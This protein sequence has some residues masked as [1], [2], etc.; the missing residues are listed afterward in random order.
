M[1]QKRNDFEIVG[2]LQK[3]PNHLR[4]IAKYFNLPPS[5]TMRILN[6][7]VEEN[8]LDF[9][10]VGKNKEFFLK[11]SPERKIYE[12]FVEH[13]K[14]LACLQN[15]MIRKITEEIAKITKNNELVI[16]FGS[17]AKGLETKTSDIDIFVETNNKQTRE[18]LE[19]LSNKLSVKMGDFDNNS[20]LGKE[21]L[22]NH[23]VLQ[24][25]ER[26]LYLQDER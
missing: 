4:S 15:P 9:K 21:I 23:I 18:D 5:T 11:D 13:Y 14:K 2:L 3:G 26:F 10:E 16:L 17:Y 1:F 24:N 22:N 12:F 20:L 7:L 8:V 19:L 6:S 25:V